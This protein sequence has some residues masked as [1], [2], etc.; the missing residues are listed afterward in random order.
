MQSEFGQTVC[1]TRGFFT[2]LWFEQLFQ[3]PVQKL[4]LN[5][6]LCLV[7]G[8]SYSSRITPDETL[9]NGMTGMAWQTGMLQLMPPHS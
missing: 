3:S 4:A 8:P 1:R 9:E 2:L 6:S 7:M 5:I